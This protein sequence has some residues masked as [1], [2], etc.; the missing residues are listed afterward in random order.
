MA[1]AGS[2]HG[3]DVTNPTRINPE[4]GTR[5]ELVHFSECLKQRG[6]GIVA[7]VVPNHMCIA[8]PANEW[9]WDVLENGPSSPFA[10]Y[11][12]INWNPPKRDLVNKVLLADPGRPIWPRS[13]KTSKLRSL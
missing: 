9:W 11:F 6:M 13:G 4:I 2:M 8:E 3:Y 10:R 5:E 12:D 1:A 7:D